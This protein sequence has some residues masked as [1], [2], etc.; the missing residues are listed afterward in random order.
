[1]FP[2]F[3]ATHSSGPGGSLGV[4]ILPWDLCIIRGRIDPSDQGVSPT[5]V[6]RGKAKNQPLDSGFLPF[7]RDIGQPGGPSG[8]SGHF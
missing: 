2:C 6:P 3:K 8:K 1:M 7:G 4:L 5:V